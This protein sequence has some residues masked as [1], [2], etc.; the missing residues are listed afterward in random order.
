MSAPAR[1]RIGGGIALLALCAVLTGCGTSLP[2]SG[3]A[4]A[5]TTGASSSCAASVL[6]T[7]GHVLTRIYHEG[8]FSERTAS[9]SHFIE[10][11]ATLREAVE[12]D[13]PKA[14]RAAAK[15]LL[16]TGHMTDLR[17]MRGTKTLVESGGPALTPITGTIKSASGAA[18][19]SWV[20]SVWSDVGYI[21]EASGVAQGFVDVRANDRSIAG[22]VGLPAGSLPDEGT[23][24]YGHVL[25]QFTS[26]AGTAYPSGSV[27]VYVLVPVDATARLCGATSEDTVVNTLKSIAELI[28]AGEVG[29]AT[30]KQID[31]VQ[32]DATLLQAVANR[33]PLATETAIKAI[34]HHHLVRLRIYGAGDEL[35]SDVGGP[36]VLAPVTAPLKLHGHKIGSMVL[37]IQDDEGYKRLTGRLEGLDVLMYMR[38]PGATKQVLVKNSLGPNPGKVPARGTYVYRGHSFRVFTVRAKAFPSGPLT[39]RVLV[40]EP[41]PLSLETEAG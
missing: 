3:S 31:R 39:I 1:R 20:A 36:Y 16:A 11:S 5:S 41:Y 18:I 25:Y 9:A 14:A 27:R 6:D 33:E 2:T 17:V 7:V 12:A 40:P 35:L 10:T 19:G 22:S 28:Y 26:F 15:T 4:R 13:S 38:P 32:S 30:L 37:S 23:L 29:P 24:T 34:L 8:V 21:D